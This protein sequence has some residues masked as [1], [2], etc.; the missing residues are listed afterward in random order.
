MRTPNI[1]P[2]P[3]DY[4]FSI[5]AKNGKMLVNRQWERELG[6]DYT[7]TQLWFIYDHGGVY[8]K[9]EY[10]DK[11]SKYMLFLKTDSRASFKG[12]TLGL[13]TRNKGETLK[14]FESFFSAGYKISKEYGKVKVDFSTDGYYADDFDYESKF[15]VGWGVT[16]AVTVSNIGEFY[17]IKGVRFY[18]TKIGIEIKI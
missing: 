10:F 12:L 17:N 18:K 3:D 8:V 1:Q 4:E 7:D 2:N 5:G 14:I 6:T 11:Q 9:P 13:T 15:N 16:K